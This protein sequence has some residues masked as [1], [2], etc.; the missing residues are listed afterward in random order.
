MN[1]SSSSLAP[2][3]MKALQR[4]R[5]FALAAG[6]ALALVAS[7]V[8]Q[9]ALD[10]RPVTALAWALLLGGAGA[11]ALLSWNQDLGRSREQPER[12]V[13]RPRWLL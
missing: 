12:S 2:T 9:R 1:H 4:L 7:Y 3:H 5:P 11:F 6:T 10:R 8:G 13:R